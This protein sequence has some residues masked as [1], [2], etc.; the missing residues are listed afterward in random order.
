M[1]PFFKSFLRNF[2]HMGGQ[3]KGG[4]E[5]DFFSFGKKKDP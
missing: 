3:T 4:L 1:G 5:D 2:F